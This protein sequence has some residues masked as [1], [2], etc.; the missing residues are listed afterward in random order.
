MRTFH[1]DTPS[2]MSQCSKWYA[3]GRRVIQSPTVRVRAGGAETTPLNFERGESVKNIKLLY[4]V[5]GYVKP[6]EYLRFLRSVSFRG[7]VT[8]RM[9]ADGFRRG[10]EQC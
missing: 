7:I 2:N 8:S 5:R 6:S 1:D 3:L 10:L 9:C 4:S